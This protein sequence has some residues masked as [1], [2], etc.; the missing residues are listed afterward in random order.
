MVFCV[1]GFRNATPKPNEIKITHCYAGPSG[2]TEASS[3]LDSIW[4]RCGRRK[5]FAGRV[6]GM[7]IP[8]SLGSGVQLAKT[9][10]FFLRWAPSDSSEEGCS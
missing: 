3:V 6:V 4:T 9:E 1:I 5:R 2:L 7:L 10:R 8:M